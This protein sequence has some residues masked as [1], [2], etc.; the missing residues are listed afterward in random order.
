[1]FGKIFLMSVKVKWQVVRK[2]ERT[3]VR[4]DFR[5]FCHA[6]IGVQKENF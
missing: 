3:C 4:E 2:P 1:M 5:A 6:E